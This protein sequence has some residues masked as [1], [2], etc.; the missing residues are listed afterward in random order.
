[1]ILYHLVSY[2]QSNFTK[3]RGYYENYCFF[4]DTTPSANVERLK[5]RF[6]NVGKIQNVFF[7]DV[8]YLL[9]NHKSGFLLFVPTRPRKHPQS[10][11]SA[12]NLLYLSY[13]QKL[14]SPGTKKPSPHQYL[15]Q[16]YSPF[17]C[18][19]LAIRFTRQLLPVLLQ[20]GSK[21][22]RIISN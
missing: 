12:E 8:V 18:T 16:L 4:S 5:R 6:L 22:N 1:M 21:S 10:F 13:Q 15:L 7:A 20:H 14:A 11:Y 9:Y 2:T 3:I 19:S 17:K